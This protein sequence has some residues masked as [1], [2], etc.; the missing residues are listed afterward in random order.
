MLRG[1]LILALA[2]CLM[3]PLSASS[4]STRNENTANAPVA[5]ADAC[6]AHVR[7]VSF[8]GDTCLYAHCKTCDWSGPKHTGSSALSEASNDAT[9]HMKEH[10]NHVTQPKSCG[11]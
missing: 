6:P 5:F 1:V 8:Q 9:N 3:T 11:D 10:P 2:S 7:R 4:L